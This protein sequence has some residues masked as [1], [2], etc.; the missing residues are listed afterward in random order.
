MIF[1][2]R[3]GG[4]IRGEGAIYFF[5]GTFSVCVHMSR[6]DVVS[7]AEGYID[8]FDDKKNRIM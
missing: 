7:F 6:N 1:C 8:V 2:S 3:F 4:D 5:P